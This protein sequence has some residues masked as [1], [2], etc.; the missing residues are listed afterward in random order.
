VKNHEAKNYI[1]TIIFELGCEGGV[2]FPTPELCQR[3]D[4]KYHNG[5]A[6]LYHIHGVVYIVRTFKTDIGNLKVHLSYL[7][8]DLFQKYLT[9]T[10]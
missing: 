2:D 7:R 4:L 1:F 10:G 5:D 6:N 3:L 8:K 9:E